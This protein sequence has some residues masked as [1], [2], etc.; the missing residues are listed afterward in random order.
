MHGIHQEEIFY[1]VVVWF[2]AFGASLARVARDRDNVS[3]WNG[4]GVGAT[5]G[6][7][8]FG[9]V[10]IFFV[11]SAA[12]GHGTWYW[13]GVSAMV[14]L[15]GKEQDMIAKT[16]ISKVFAVAKLLQESNNKDDTE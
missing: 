15:L 4:L 7:Y 1:Y 12:S 8:G 13:I 14:G 3:L 6:F 5:S 9:V 2:I 16:L 11:P 10:A